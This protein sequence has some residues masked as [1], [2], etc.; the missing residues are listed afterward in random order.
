MA[1]SYEI[2]SQFAKVV[3]ND[4][5]QTGKET[6]VYGV[7]ISDGNGN[8]YVKLDGS[9]QLTPLSEDERP[10]ADSTVAATEVGDR[11]SVSIKNHTATVTGNISSPSVRSDDFKDLVDNVDEINKFDIVLADKVQ[12]NEGYIKK[13]QTDKAEV[14]DLKAATA[15]ITELEAGKASIDDLKAAKG[16]IGE[17]LL[18]CGADVWK[19]EKIE[20]VKEVIDSLL[21][22]CV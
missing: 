20:T 6:T 10:S 9:D 17:A 3:N 11:V 18:F 16:E 4:K 15:K 21:G 13:L 1:L 19:A 5:K 22:D 8:K 2:I 14:G 7:V 12:A